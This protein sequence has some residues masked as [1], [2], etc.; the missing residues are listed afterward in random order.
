[1]SHSRID[2][3]GYKKQFAQLSLRDQSMKLLSNYFQV[4]Q[5]RL[6]LISNE[7][8]GEVLY[9]P[10]CQQIPCAEPNLQ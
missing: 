5:D 3:R 8:T 4:C 6:D 7:F 10:S 2:G 1:M 9:L